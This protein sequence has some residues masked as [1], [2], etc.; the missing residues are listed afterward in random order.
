MDP[1]N[2]K[3]LLEIKEHDHF[4]LASQL[5]TYLRRSQA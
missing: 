3:S 2:R 5:C 1:E 4:L